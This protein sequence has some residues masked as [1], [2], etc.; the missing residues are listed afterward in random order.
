MVRGRVAIQLASTGGVYGAE[1]ALLE[2]A[3]YLR[4]RGWQSCVVALE[5][6]G[7]SDLVRRASALG[8][9]AHS[10]VPAG[11]MAVLPML[12]RLRRLLAGYPRAVVHSHGY[13]PD[14][15]LALL[16]APHRLACVST[17]HSWYSETTKLRILEVADKRVLRRF[18]H[19][20]A[21]SK[22]I[23]SELLEGGVAEERLTLI[24]NGI[25]APPVDP[26]AREQV[27][28]E[29][30]LPS[31][32]RLI[33]QIGRLTGSKRNDLLIAAM[34]RLREPACVH[35]VFAGDGEERGRLADQAAGS[36]LGRQVH[37]IGYRSDVPRLLCA[38]D[39]VVV[40]SDKEGLP[41][42]ILEA[43]ALRCP[44]VSTAVGA[45]PDALKEGTDAWVVRSNDAAVL[46]AAIDEA[47]DNPTL[48]RARA[49]SAYQRFRAGYSRDA[50]GRAY[51]EI[52]NRVW[53]ARGWG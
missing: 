39:V 20:V 50:M 24:S 16:N 32:C 31:N 37:F 33:L 52:Y 3:D 10:F 53:T 5:G 38:A 6:R 21:V 19:V 2:L 14:I 27:R 48:A 46:A 34:T 26:S 22:E 28:A 15:L 1:R 30:G 8:L 41:I 7:A 13:K 35:V 36:G 11:R 45:I 9:A 17:C 44:I 4:D 43:M 49:E 12:L 40:S 51:L 18:D 47:L 42:I 25:S 23:R 29:F